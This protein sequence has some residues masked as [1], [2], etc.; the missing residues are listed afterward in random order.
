MEEGGRH[1]L[2]TLLRHYRAAAGLTQ[3][4]LAER[5][6]LSRRR[7]LADGINQRRDCA[8]VQNIRHDGEAIAF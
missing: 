3:E 2:G 5:A 7:R 6:R 4:E 1:G 8:G